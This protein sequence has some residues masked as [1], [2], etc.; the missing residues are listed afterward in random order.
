[1][2]GYSKTIPQEQKSR[3]RWWLAGGVCMMMMQLR[4]AVQHDTTRG[5]I[6]GERKMWPY[7]LS[8]HDTTRH[9]R[10]GQ[11]HVALIWAQKSDGSFRGTGGRRDVCV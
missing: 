2:F 6:Y 8:R 4:C 1:M 7:R 9:V 11:L 10:S 5:C 3:K